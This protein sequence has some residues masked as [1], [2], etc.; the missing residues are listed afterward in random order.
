MSPHLVEFIS[1]AAAD[2]IPI[3]IHALALHEA[4]ND[5]KAHEVLVH[6]SAKLLEALAPKAAQAM[7][8]IVEG[9]E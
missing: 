2:E 7:V 3:V 1:K 6:E 8:H 5:D 4:G 9:Y